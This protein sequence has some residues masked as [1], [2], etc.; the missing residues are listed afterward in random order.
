MDK[1][2]LSRVERGLVRPSVPALTRILDALGAAEV[3]G[4]LREQSDFIDQ[5]VTPPEE[6]R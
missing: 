5:L 6:G 2:H 3:A 1:A 4:I